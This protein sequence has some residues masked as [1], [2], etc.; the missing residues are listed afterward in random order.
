MEMNVRVSPK[1]S[2]LRFDL[3]SRRILMSRSV[4]RRGVAV[5][6]SGVVVAGFVA[7]GSP[8]QAA[9]PAAANTAKG[10]APA[11]VTSG[12][13][14]SAVSGKSARN[15]DGASAGVGA[16]HVDGVCNLFSNGDGD[17]CLWYLQNYSGSHADFFFGD[18]NLNNDRFNSAGAGQGAIVGNNAESDYNYDRRL[19]AQVY[20]GT[21][22]TGTFGNVAPN[23]GGNFTATFRNNVESFK[24]I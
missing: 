16:A 22:Y 17:F 14:S 3:D 20:T 10:G 15:G 21:N 1:P 9:D 11:A 8:A 7:L 18:T 23:S 5:A 19:T 6:F 12:V 4:I 13:G 24:W 2:G